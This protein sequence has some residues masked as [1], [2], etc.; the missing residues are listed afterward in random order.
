MNT[1]LEIRKGLEQHR[2]KLDDL[3]KHLKYINRLLEISKWLTF[4]LYLAFAISIYLADIMH[5][6]TFLESATGSMIGFSFYLVVCFMLAYVLAGIKHAAYSHMALF[7]RVVLIV[8][9]VVSMGLMAEVF[10]SSGNQDMK[11]RAIAENSAEFKA[12]V[13]DKPGAVVSNH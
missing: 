2:L 5:L 12:L 10:Q 7:G 8:A 3:V 11:A 13:N 6:R 9:V 1:E 4:G